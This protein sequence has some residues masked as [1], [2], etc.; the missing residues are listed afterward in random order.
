MLLLPLL[1][2][3]PC[4]AKDI[5]AEQTPFG[6][7]KALQEAREARRLD[8]VKD[9]NII[10]RSGTYH[11]IQP[12]I[13]RP[14]DNGICL[15]GEGN[16]VISGGVEITDWKKEGKMLVAD[17]P[18]FNGRPLEFRQLYI[19]GQK[20]VRARDVQ[21]F[22]KMYKILSMDKQKEVLYVPADAVKNIVRQSKNYA[23]GLEMTLHE[24]WC[25]ANLRIRKIEMMGDS[26]AVFFHNPESHIH[27]SH[28]WPSP[29]TGT[30]GHN[31]A[32]Y[33][34][35]DR[36]LLDC[37]GEWFLD[38]KLQKIYYLPK[39]GET[40]NNIKAIAPAVETLLKSEGT[41]D[42]LVSNITIQNISFEHSTWMRPSI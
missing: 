32:F 2:L 5:V 39:E 31:S 11:I 4:S 20:A 33:L 38:T 28:P 10:L 18:M 1:S 19:N 13:L 3:M 16:A 23:A 7:E 8:G 30:D 42:E 21:D 25:V 41:P 15:K 37:P 17:V 14:E 29:M 9:I 40:T 22:E 36:S 27:F 12:I 6:I 24:M 34:S 26:A 35:N